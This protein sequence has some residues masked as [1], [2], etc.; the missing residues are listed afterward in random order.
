[1]SIGK[2]GQWAQLFAIGVLAPVLFFGSGCA[3]TDQQREAAGRFARASKGIGTFGS[4]ELRRMRST[5]IELNTTN[6][7][8]GGRPD[9]TGLD[10]AFDPD[11]VRVRVTAAEA[12]ASYGSLLLSL[13][14]ASQE[15]E[16]ANASDAFV[17]SFNALAADE[18][19]GGRI[20]A[21]DAQQTEALGTI[22]RGIGGIFVEWQKA[23]AV[24]QIVEETQPAVDGVIALLIAD[25]DKASPGLAAGFAG[26]LE[27][28]ERSSGK[29]LGNDRATESQKNLAIE[30]RT[31]L[32]EESARLDTVSARASAVLAQLR[33][34]SAELSSAMNEEISIAQI[35]QL[36]G[37]LKTLADA[38]R[39]ATGS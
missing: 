10:G 4:E 9:P 8:L 17:G 14:E 29:V 20:P 35:K 7:K 15:D 28:L 22:V 37:D 34:A 13:V 36:G 21:L 23:R 12:L 33:S 24:K 6:L 18:A 27:R 1:M 39:V 26:T 38:A 11:D 2:R 30:A 25:F 5:T 16:L 19:V 3:L 31:A 32:T